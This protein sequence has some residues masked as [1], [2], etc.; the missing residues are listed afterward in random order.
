MSRNKLIFKIISAENNKE[1]RKRMD[2]I[3]WLKTK[4]KK[5]L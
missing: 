2:R 5:Q 3:T 1:T 4:Q